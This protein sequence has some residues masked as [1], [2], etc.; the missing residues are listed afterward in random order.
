MEYA[1]KYNSQGGTSQVE[2]CVIEANSLLE[3]PEAVVEAYCARTV[4]LFETS[5]LGWD[6]AED[7]KEA[8]C[9]FGKWRRPFHDVAVDSTSL[10]P[11]T[12]VCR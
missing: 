1:E 9:H 12:Q 7:R 4:L 5:M 6:Q 11:P 10:H 3:R 8:E 2:I